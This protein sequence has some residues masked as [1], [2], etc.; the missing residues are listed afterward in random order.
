MYTKLTFLV[1]S[2]GMY[3]QHAFDTYSD[4]QAL[5]A[6]NSSI[7]AQLTEALS[8]RNVEICTISKKLE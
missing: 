6:E 7:R 2:L 1:H 4:T 5:E 8:S 3:L